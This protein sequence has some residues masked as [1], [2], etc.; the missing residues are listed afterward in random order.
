MQQTARSSATVGRVFYV[1]TMTIARGLGALQMFHIRG[2]FMTNYGADLVGTAWLYAMFRQGRTVIR[3]GRVMSPGRT[4]A[5][6]FIACAAS[7]LAQKLRLFPGVFD[8]LDF[9]AYAASVLACYALDRRV[10]LSA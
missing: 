5:F 3:P 9:F 6:I 4:T 7:E 8:P 2:G 10:G 1:T